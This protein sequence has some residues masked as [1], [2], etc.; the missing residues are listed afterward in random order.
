LV[1]E[2]HPR[3]VFLDLQASNLNIEMV[4]KEL[5]SH[6]PEPLIIGFGSHVDQ[7]TL[8]AASKA[9]CDVALPRSAFV[10]R[11]PREMGEWLADRRDSN[12]PS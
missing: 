4:V 8:N 7:A 1:I 12:S 3:A 5:K 2:Q 10:Q 11:L 6:Q 9:G